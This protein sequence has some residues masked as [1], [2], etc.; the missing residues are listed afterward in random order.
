MAC[1]GVC[2]AEALVA[3][4]DAPRLSFIESRCHQCGMCR[5]ACPENC[6][7]L[8]PRLLCDTHAPIARPSS[9][10]RNPF[11][12]SMRAAVCFGEHGQPNAGKACRTLDVQRQSTG[13]TTADV[14]HMRNPAMFTRQETTKN[15]DVNV[16]DKAV[17]RI[18]RAYQ[19]SGRTAMCC[20]PPY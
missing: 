14:P 17:D 16:T 18:L 5:T 10:K 20:L 6:I 8:Q 2:P 13:E 11:Y 12:V 4:G 9:M 15:E 7:T 19:V 3:D 1:V